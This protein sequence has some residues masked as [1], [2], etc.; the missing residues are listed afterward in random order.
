[1]WQKDKSPGGQRVNGIPR[2]KKKQNPVIRRWLCALAEQ[3]WTDVFVRSCLH[4][5]RRRKKTP[6]TNFLL[7]H[8]M[9]HE[10]FPMRLPY[11]S[12][13][14]YSAFSCTDT[15]ALAH[16]FSVVVCFRFSFFHRHEIDAT[17]KKQKKKIQQHNNNNSE[18]NCLFKTCIAH[19]T[20]PRRHTRVYLSTDTFHWDERVN[21]KPTIYFFI[22]L[23]HLQSMA[24]ASG[25]DGGGGAGIIFVVSYI[26]TRYLCCLW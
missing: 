2:K 1:M 7:V 9:D 20:H 16:L 10:I 5:W 25:A 24:A 17:M 19:T 23:C 15:L 26:L 12:R 6:D 3:I 11:V 14:D 4:R 22:S 13:N 8:E 18:T 21:M